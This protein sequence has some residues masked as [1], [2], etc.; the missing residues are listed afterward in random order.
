LV[1]FALGLKTSDEF[2]DLFAQASRSYVT[3]GSLCRTKQPLKYIENC[4]G[5]LDS[6]T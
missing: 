1:A 3:F 4:L 6:N 2:M 5:I